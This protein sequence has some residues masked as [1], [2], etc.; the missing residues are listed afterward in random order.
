MEN[1]C[2]NRT[3]ISRTQNGPPNCKFWVKNT[4]K[5]TVK[6]LKICNSGGRFEVLE[7]FLRKWKILQKKPKKR[8]FWK[9]PEKRKFWKF[10][11]KNGEF[12]I[13]LEKMENF[14]KKMEFFTTK[15]ANKLLINP[16]PA[17]KFHQ[18]SMNATYMYF[19]CFTVA[20]LISKEFLAWVY[21]WYSSLGR[22]VFLLFRLTPWQ[23]FHQSFGV[24]AHVEYFKILKPAKAE[25]ASDYNSS[26]ASD[27]STG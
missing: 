15:V 17:N 6:I 14:V 21:I 2:K 9:K 12:W 20:E 23:P 8:K 11:V 4:V 27:D 18:K 25:I 3:N 26:K 24:I 13:F 19:Y 7:I 1:W 16:K 5:I 10:L 22:F